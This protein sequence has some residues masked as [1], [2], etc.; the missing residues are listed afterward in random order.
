MRKW[1]ARVLA[2]LPLTERIPTSVIQRDWLCVYPVT[3]PYDPTVSTFS[4]WND[5]STG[6]WGLFSYFMCLFPLLF[7]WRCIDSRAPMSLTG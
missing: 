6:V 7:F 2:R 3:G 5:S 4:L 1:E